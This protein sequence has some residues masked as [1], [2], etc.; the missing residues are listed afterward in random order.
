M[1]NAKIDALKFIKG[2]PHDLEI[3]N[4]G[5][6]FAK[7]GFDYNYFDKKGFNFA[8][9]PQPLSY[10]YKILNQY[11]GNLKKGAIVVVVAVCPFEFSVAEYKNDDSNYKYY[12][13]LNEQQINNYSKRKTFFVKYCSIALEPKLI[14]GAIKMLIKK[15]IK[16]E[17]RKTDDVAG[18]IKQ[19][20]KERIDGWKGQFN[21]TNLT[22]YAS[23]ERLEETF[24]ETTNN[25]RKILEL[26]IEN[27]FCPVIINMPACKEESDEFSEEI[28][29]KFY[30]ENIKKANVYKIPVI[31]YFRDKR[32][33]DHSLYMNAD[34]LNDKGREFFAKIFTEDL[35]KM[36]LWEV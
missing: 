22:K 21:L 6:T 33:H 27:E 31:D 18:T 12:F 34:C 15:L 13:F 1:T 11:K 25:L 20:A 7:Y 8:I 24:R 23:D 5:S 10:D 4:T 16:Y 29:E 9:A 19:T 26:C 2:V 35:K 3:V 17:S 30:N 32:F 28:I 14:F 36:G